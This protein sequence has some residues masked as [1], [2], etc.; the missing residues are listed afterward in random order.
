MS[1]Y[2]K[3]VVLSKKEIEYLRYVLKTWVINEDLSE[4]ET[5]AER[6]ALDKLKE[7]FC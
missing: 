2:K 6:K 5:A 3:V 4:E 7:I 1:Y